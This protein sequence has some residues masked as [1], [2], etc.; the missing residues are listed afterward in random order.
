MTEK[1][2]TSGAILPAMIRFALPMLAA[3]LLQAAY[4]A[5]DLLIVGNFGDATGVSAVGSGSQVMMLVT[6]IIIGLTMGAT[7]L[8][9]QRIG[10]KRPDE[11]GAVVGA[12]IALFIVTAALLTL[13]MELVSAPLCRMMQTPP[14]AFDKTVQYVRICSAG[15]IFIT[16]YNVISGI[17]RGLGNSKL[18][19]IFVAIAAAANVAGD[20]LLCGALHMDVAGAAIATIS[21]QALSVVLSLVII[22]RRPLPFTLRRSQIT[23]KTP[24]CRHILRLGVPLATVDGLVHFSFVVVNSFANGFGLDASAGY[25]VGN[26]LIGFVLLVPSAVGQ[27]VTAFVSQNVGAGKYGRAKQALFRAMT[28]GLVCGVGLF[29]LGFF[30]GTFLASLF[31]QEAAVIREAATFLRGFAPDCIL[32]CVLFAFTGFYNGHGRTTWVMLQGILS[33]TFIRIPAAWLFSVLEGTTLFH[34]GLATPITTAVAILF[35]LFCFRSMQRK[36]PELLRDT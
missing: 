23:L 3:L 29:C 21:A 36:N 14:E 34:L 33:A 9:G 20:L 5:A 15:I 1:N 18:P 27:S 16:A 35:Y 7:V 13:I 11:A 32:T 10:E 25:G 8:I 19:M 17:F 24:N 30:G 6:C 22:R 28:A 4:G 26:R 2:F 12:A 31:S